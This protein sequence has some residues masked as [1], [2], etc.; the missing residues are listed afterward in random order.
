MAFFLIIPPGWIEYKNAADL[1]DM[2]A[3][4]AQG[5]NHGFASFTPHDYESLAA[6][7]HESGVITSALP[8]LERMTT[9]ANVWIPKLLERMGYWDIEPD[10]YAAILHISREDWHAWQHGALETVS[11]D[12]ALSA[13]LIW[14]ISS[15]LYCFVGSWEAVSHWLAQVR[16]GSVFNNRSPLDMIKSGDIRELAKLHDFLASEALGSPFS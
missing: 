6:R 10:L 3:G 5:E 11:I 12:A 15:F 2:T 8:I 13:R 16:N 4:S 14:E 7:N 1:L 9:N